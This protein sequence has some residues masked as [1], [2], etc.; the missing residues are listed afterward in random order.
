MNQISAHTL[1]C[2]LCR[3]RLK[4][5]PIICII[6]NSFSFRYVTSQIRIYYGVFWFLLNERGRTHEH[7]VECAC[8][9][10]SMWETHSDSAHGHCLVG[11]VFK[12]AT[13]GIRCHSL[14][15]WWRLS[16]SVALLRAPPSGLGIACIRHKA[17]CTEPRCPYRDGSVGNTC[18]LPPLIYIYIWHIHIYTHTHTYIY[19]YIYI[20]IL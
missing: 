9:R 12:C 19:I 2:H 17:S 18:T 16:N 4:Y 14:L 7:K 10:Q 5:K 20:Y 11:F 6:N 13:H 15:F 1:L 3:T 8:L